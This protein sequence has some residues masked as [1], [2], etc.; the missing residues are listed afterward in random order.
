RISR[1]HL[2]P[3][4]YAHDGE[5][6]RAGRVNSEL[7][8]ALLSEPY[9][10][11]PAPKS[12][13][14]ERFHGQYVADALSRLESPIADVDLVAT[15]TELT[16]QTVARDV[17]KHGVTQLVVSGGGSHNP[18][19]MDGLRAQLPGVAVVLSDDFSASVD[20]KDVIE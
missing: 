12:T 4:G 20:D 2:H 10:E 6:A 17:E 19:I 9:Y 8:N 11:L 1:R 7:L 16:V 3:A 18:V 5:I 13:G 14:K 15:L